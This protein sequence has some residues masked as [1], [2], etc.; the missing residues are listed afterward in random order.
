MSDEKEADLKKMGRRMAQ[1]RRTQMYGFWVSLAYVTSAALGV[2]M[3]PAFGT[4]NGIV[5]IFGLTLGYTLLSLR[6][7]RA[8]EVGTVLL[9]GAPIHHANPGLHFVPAFVCRLVKHTR[10]HIQLE[11]GASGSPA[12]QE[13][14]EEGVHVYHM[15]RSYETTWQDARTV[16]YKDKSLKETDAK[17]TTGQ[18]L[19]SYPHL[20]ARYHIDPR[21]N[22]HAIFLE[23]IGSIAQTNMQIRD[24]AEVAV[25][26]MAG[27]HSLAQARR[28]HTALNRELTSQ[29]EAL[30]GEP[31]ADLYQRD[32]AG[33][34]EY[35]TD[36]EGNY[37]KD[38]EG[39][40]IPILRKKTDWWGIDVT[41]ARISSFGIPKAVNDALNKAS[42]AI[43]LRDATITEA[44][45]ERQRL[46]LTGRGRA[47]AQMALYRA[48]A[49]GTKLLAK[50]LG[51]EEGKLAR[52]LEEM[53]RAVENGNADLTFFGGN[54]NEFVGSI[55]AAAT[56]A[57]RS[58]SSSGAA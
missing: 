39:N 43:G 22:A 14:V 57:M 41:D 23:R 44:E 2:A 20:V 8:D 55:T 24:T 1:N 53:R 32:S 4:A 42:S 5:A 50:Q 21:E 25:Q 36:D 30:V 52:Q 31:G 35:E 16:E 15:E 46:E 18:E 17:A 33:Y 47:N 13:P 58:S 12:D 6:Q 54:F 29:L 26:T 38:D 10:N 56:K 27:R 28:G 11:F 3:I 51:T 19:T 37:K 7:V 9:F 45:G 40:K 48:E 49:A 34:V